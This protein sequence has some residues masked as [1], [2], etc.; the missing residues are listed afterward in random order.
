MAIRKVLIWP[1]DCLTE[2]AAKIDDVS[3]ESIQILASDLVDT[4]KA[5]NAE[6][7][8]ATQVGEMV[9]M[10]VLRSEGDNPIVLINPEVVESSEETIRSSE[11]CLSFPGVMAKVDRSRRVT[12]KALTIQGDEVEVNLVDKEAVAFQHENDHLRGVTMLD[13]LGK[14]EKR[15]ALKRLSKAKRNYKRFIRT[16]ATRV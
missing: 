5:Y 6:G 4:L 3:E 14:M 2:E 8:A 13:H 15:L 1:H 12:V 10:M 11:G 16:A 7:V 9:Q